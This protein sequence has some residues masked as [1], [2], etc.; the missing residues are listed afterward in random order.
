MKYVWEEEDLKA[1]RWFY[2]TNS[3]TAHKLGFTNESKKRSEGKKWV[4]VSITDGMTSNAKTNDEM[5]KILN[6]KYRPLPQH[7]LIEFIEE[8]RFINENGNL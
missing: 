7:K 2:R 5:L 1:G 3:S 8:L 4:Y 6:E